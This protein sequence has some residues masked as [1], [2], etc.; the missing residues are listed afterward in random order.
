LAQGSATL[1]SLPVNRFRNS[2]SALLV[3]QLV[4]LL[5]V[6]QLAPAGLWLVS[7]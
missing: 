7:V 4:L 5:A 1:A 6:W 2:V 3:A